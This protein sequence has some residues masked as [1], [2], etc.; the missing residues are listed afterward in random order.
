[1]NGAGPVRRR[2]LRRLLLLSSSS[3]QPACH[4]LVENPE[5]EK[6]AS[7]FSALSVMAFLLCGGRVVKARV[8]VF[9]LFV[10]PVFSCEK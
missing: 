2:H 6:L 8:V 7:A 4:S 9:S 5:R 10:S 1:V 3:P